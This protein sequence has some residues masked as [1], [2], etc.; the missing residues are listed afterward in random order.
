MAVL[1]PA[2][3]SCVTRMTTGEKRFAQ[4]LEALLEADYLCWYD[5][6]VG[7]KYQHPDFV[8]LHP[9]HGVL[10]LEVKDW[11][12]DAI[13]Q[14]NPVSVTLSTADGVKQVGNPLL[15]A[16]QNAFSVKNALARDAQ[17]I[18]PLGQPHAGQLICP[19][20]FGVVL[21]K[22]TREQF[23]TS[24]L[25][26]VLLPHLVI[27]KDEMTESIDAGV[28]R[29]RLSAMFNVQFPFLLTTS[30]IDRVRWHMFPDIR[31]SQ[32]DL[33]A[34]SEATPCN[35]STALM[36]TMDLQQERLARSLG[37]GH[38]VI[39]G[40]AGSGKTLI[41]GFRCAH[42]AQS[43]GKPILV[44]CYNIALAAKLDDMMRSRGLG[45][46]VCVRNFHAWCYDQL[47]L[48]R[49]AK[50]T[51]RTGDRYY[52]D[53]VKA[54]TDAVDGGQIPRGQY[55]A[56][57]IDEGHDFEAAWLQLAT[58]MVDPSENSLLLLYDDAQAIYGKKR[59]NA[60][61]FKGVGI[62]A[63][64][65]TTILRVNYRN[66][67]EI[68]ECAHAFAKD[69]LTPAEADEDNVPLLMPEM[70]GRH[71]IAPVLMHASSLRA[72][73]DYIASQ[74]GK[75]NAQ[76][77]PWNDM[78]VLYHANFMA[79]EI[80]AA[81]AAS[82][83]PVTCLNDRKSKRFDPRHASVKIMTLH[84]SKGLEFA[85]VAIAGLG[86]MPYKV[87]QADNEARLL[88]VGMTR[89]TEKLILT[90]SRQSAFVVKLAEY[91]IAA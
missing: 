16:R 15:Q 51:W 31:I 66:T 8:V 35:S 24:A 17:L 50:P 10:I 70:A 36:R 54:V 89:A 29:E 5:V 69:I 14:I 47:T 78:A 45:N 91:R 42:L 6:P 13:K 19:Y 1:I 88:Y 76:G 18:G 58:Q 43:V 25:D 39:H 22:I 20:G 28:F 67:N 56:V 72:E 46:R 3:N 44:L 87:D 79:D 53:L 63:R 74:L 82:G 38:R 81:F 64:G 62:Q 49:V 41:L 59:S 21:T 9:R 52:V 86:S 80:K 12:C 84:S 68:L 48:Y 61:S 40:V 23:Y 71:G 77:T 7:T 26:N 55:G 73:A 65:R 33:F 90:A 30:Q 60:F 4:R 37:D 11:S 2:Y 32:T 75:M 83:I 85:V 27:C 34:N 57:L